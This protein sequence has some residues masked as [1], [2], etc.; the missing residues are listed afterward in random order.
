MT[1]CNHDQHCDNDI[2][3]NRRFIGDDNDGDID[4][5]T[6]PNIEKSKIWNSIK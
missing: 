5:Y 2:I 6:E 4:G 1:L 3:A